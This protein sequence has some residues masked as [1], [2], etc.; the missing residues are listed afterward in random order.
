MGQELALD[1][2]CST[3]VVTDETLF[4][5]EVKLPSVLWLAWVNR[6]L[7]IVVVLRQ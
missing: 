2:G 6:L 3:A 1:F 7:W 4:G 5:C